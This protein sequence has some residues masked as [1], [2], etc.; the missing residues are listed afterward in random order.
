MSCPMGVTNSASLNQTHGRDIILRGEV[1][2][3]G[4]ANKAV[5]LWRC[6]HQAA[7]KANL[8]YVAVKANARTKNQ[9]IVA[10]I[11][12]RAFAPAPQRGKGACP[13]EP[14]SRCRF[15]LASARF[16][17]LHQAT[18]GP[19]IPPTKSPNRAKLSHYKASRLFG[20]NTIH[21]DGLIEI[22]E[23]VGTIY[24]V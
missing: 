17:V 15:L 18:T 24:H 6:K 16:V 19:T 5:A 22:I 11:E 10:A 13:T 14:K 1:V 7:P 23:E 12:P 4:H 8:P 21:F 2:A 20:S 9:A 3:A